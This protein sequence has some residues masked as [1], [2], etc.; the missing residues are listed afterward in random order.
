MFFVRTVSKD[1]LAAVSTLLSETW[2]DT[3]DGI[4]G[5][6]K[7][8]EITASWHSID[9]LEDQ[10]ERPHSEFIVADDG[11]RLG[12]VAFAAMSEQ[13]SSDQ[14]K[15]AMLHQLYVHPDCQGQGIGLDLLEEISNAL[16]DASIL[17][18]EVDPAN[19]KAVAFYEAAGFAKTVETQD[20]GGNS[21]IP[22][23]VYELQLTRAG[24]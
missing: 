8:A 5:R 1:D 23:D 11:T 15:V 10:L 7:V 2:H 13:A 9:T 6:G 19:T 18:L 4:Y 12:G 14:A 22:A 21:G 17:K 16:S 20:C 24:S 3:Y